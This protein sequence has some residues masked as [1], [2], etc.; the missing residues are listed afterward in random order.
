[1]GVSH[2]PTGFH[3]SEQLYSRAFLRASEVRLL[4]RIA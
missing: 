1:M 4:W 3:A 2:E